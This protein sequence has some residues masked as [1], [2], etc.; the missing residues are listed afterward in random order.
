MCTRQR[1]F[2]SQVINYIYPVDVVGTL[3]DLF[4]YEIGDKILGHIFWETVSLSLGF[5]S[6]ETMTSDFR[7]LRSFQ[8]TFIYN[9]CYI[10]V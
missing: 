6:V 9:K 5:S 8:S 1:Q 10:L 2:V 7:A 3:K 4:L